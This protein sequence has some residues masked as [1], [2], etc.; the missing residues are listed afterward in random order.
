MKYIKFSSLC[1][2][3]MLFSCTKL[4]EKLQGDLNATDFR[5]VADVPGLLKS[6][7]NSYERTIPGPNGCF[8]PRGYGF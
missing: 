2:M 1:A 4:E 7:Y 8:L 3:V 5:Q 6:C